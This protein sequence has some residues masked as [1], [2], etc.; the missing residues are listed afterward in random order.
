[1]TASD[2]K[3]SSSR[4]QKQF[5]KLTPI[6]LGMDEHIDSIVA[7]WASDNAVLVNPIAP[8]TSNFAG[9]NDPEV[10]A[11]PADG[12]ANYLAGTQEINDAIVALNTTGNAVAAWEI[13]SLCMKYGRPC[14]KVIT[15][16]IVSVAD[17]LVELA[18]TGGREG[19]K[20]EIANWVLHL[21]FD[22][23]GKNVFQNYEHYHRHR[24]AMRRLDEEML[25][26]RLAYNKTTKSGIYAA[27]AAETG[28]EVERLKRLHEQWDKQHGSF[29][30]RAIEAAVKD[31][32]AKAS[33][34]QGPSV[35]DLKPL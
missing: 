28:Y 3:P 5:D 16:F 23:G 34:G 26:A 11:S 27:V 13:Y 20:G 12:G 7:L 25:P 15:D 35:A 1:M 30:I 33:A 8:E 32:R 14:P 22:D 17:R 21:Q 4:R 6:G 24:N 2:K 18:K 10:T 29:S 9:P 31:A 19:A